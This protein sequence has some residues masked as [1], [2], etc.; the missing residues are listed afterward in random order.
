MTNKE[1][2]SSTRKTAI[3]VG[4]LFIIATVAGVLSVAFLG[5]VLADPD[6]LNNFAANES[7][8]IAGAI[9]WL[10]FA[11]KLFR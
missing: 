8:V 10:S 7:Q 3:T 6:Y 5:V 4:I 11:A 1:R 9:T 2:M